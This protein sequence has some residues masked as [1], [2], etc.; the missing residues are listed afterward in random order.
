[1]FNTLRNNKKQ[2][3][4]LCRIFFKKRILPSIGFTFLEIILTIAIM[5][6]AMIPIMRILP[7]ALVATSRLNRLAIKSLL[8][9]RKMEELRHQILGR[10]PDYGFGKNYSTSN[11]IAYQSPYNGFYYLISDEDTLIGYQKS[12]T[13]TIWFDDN[14]DGI[15]QQS[16]IF[17][18]TTFFANRG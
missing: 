14:N 13:V 8:A 15:I 11:P 2:L 3:L 17:N 5:S 16:E 18:L 10:N 7:D 12:I 6:I 9:E 4:A 1:M